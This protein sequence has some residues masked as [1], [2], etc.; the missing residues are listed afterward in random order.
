MLP[1][2]CFL[3]RGANQKWGRPLY[4]E[5]LDTID[6]PAMYKIT[7]QKRL[8]QNLV[9]EYEKFEDL[10]LVRL[11][12]PDLPPQKKRDLSSYQFSYNLPWAH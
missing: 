1:A 4:F 11:P 6:I 8:L 9:V 5:Q 10:K 2:L 3:E 12:S 7:T